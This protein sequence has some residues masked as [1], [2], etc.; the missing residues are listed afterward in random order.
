MRAR[1]QPGDAAATLA[2]LDRGIDRCG[3]LTGLQRAA[4]A[5]EC[6]LARHTTALGRVDALV[7]KYRPSITFSM[8]RAEIFEA[9]GR[10]REAAAA[11]D[12]ALS[13]IHPLEKSAEGEVFRLRQ[14]ILGR[15]AINLRRDRLL[16]KNETIEKIP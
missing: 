13:L 10:H 1:G 12:S 15:Q 11:C 8:L 14:E 3:G 5:L 7:T 16:R 4:I 9:A 2:V 6:S